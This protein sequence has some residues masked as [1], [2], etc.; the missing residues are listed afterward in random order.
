MK[1]KLIIVVANVKHTSWWWN[2]KSEYEFETIDTLIDFMIEHMPLTNKDVDFIYRNDKNKD[3]GRLACT[4]GY[5]IE[6]GQYEMTEYTS[7]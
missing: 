7:F 5:E 1:Y 6:K 2:G 4:L 3:N